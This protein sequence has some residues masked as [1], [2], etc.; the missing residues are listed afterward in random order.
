MTPIVAVH[1]YA[2]SIMMHVWTQM[3][4]CKRRAQ[5]KNKDWSYVVIS[6]IGHV[7]HHFVGIHM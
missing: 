6:L 4:N 1:S 5:K 7:S 2:K 3:V